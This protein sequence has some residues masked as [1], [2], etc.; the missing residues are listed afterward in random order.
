M[1]RTFNW[2]DRR[3]IPNENIS[4]HLI[5]PHEGDVKSFTANFK[6]WGTLGMPPDAQVYVEPYANTSSMRFSFGTV[7][8][9]VTPQDTSLSDLDSGA[10]VLF[11]VKVVDETGQIG[12]ILAV[13]NAIRA[14][15][16]SKEDDRKAL[17][18]VAHRDL[19]EAI[20]S[21]DLLPGVQPQLVLNNRIAGLGDRLRDDPVFQGAV[22]PHAVKAI[23]DFIFLG[24]ETQDDEQWVKDWKEF[25]ASTRGE[26]IDD[27]IDEEVLL[28]IL[29]K[30]VEEFSN[31]TAW[32]QKYRA[33][34]ENIVGAAH[35]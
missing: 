6:D 25:A 26:A 21:V 22:L 7:S 14:E 23:L 33:I 27:D 31:Q 17:L 9:L 32:V 18:P 2:T 8:S 30:V 29:A 24:N 5:S 34:Q 10:A 15:N 3:P 11:R 20:W 19:G 28:P 1:K 13:A 35:D 12:R 4:I 16:E